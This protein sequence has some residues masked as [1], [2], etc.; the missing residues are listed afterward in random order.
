MKSVL[1]KDLAVRVNV[2]IPPRLSRFLDEY[3]TWHGLESRSAVVALA[4]QTLKDIDM[5]QGYAELAEYQSS[6]PESLIGLD[7]TDGLED[8]SRV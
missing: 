2:T 3:K 4:I 8:A 7:L 6:H 1:E 5:E